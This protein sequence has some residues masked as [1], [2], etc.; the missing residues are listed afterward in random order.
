MF[1]ERKTTPAVY[2][3][4]SKYFKGKLLFGEARKSD[5]ELTSK[6]KIAKFPTVMVI[7]DGDNYQGKIYEGDSQRD[8]M[9]D[10]LR[11]YAYAAKAAKKESKLTELN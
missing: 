9:M 10:F 6:F 2:K 7:T 3:S 11:E 4:L 1:T 8:H 5:T